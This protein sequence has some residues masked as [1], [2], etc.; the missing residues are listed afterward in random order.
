MR[1]RLEV[2]RPLPEDRG[3]PARPPLDVAA[4][5]AG[6]KL[7]VIGGTGFLG[8]VWWAMLLHRYP[9]IGHLYLVVRA[10][11]T[12]DPEARFWADVATS[13]CLAPLRDAHPGALYDAF[14]KS[15]VTPID[16]DVSR[17]FCGVSPD[18]IA[19]LRGSVDAVVN[20]AGLVDF[21]PPL[22]E[23]LD[24]NA[25][26]MQNLVALA[27]E[28]GSSPQ[29]EDGASSQRALAE[30][31]ASRAAVPVLHTS[32]CYVA[33]SRCGAVDEVDPRH[34][35]FPR[36]GELERAHWDPAREIAECVDLV[37]QAR[38]RCD[39]AFRQSG[40]VDQAKQNLLAR[41]EPVTGEPF[42][43]ELKRVRRKFIES[44]LADTGL[45]R[46]KFWGWPNTYTYTKSIGEQI[47]AASGV[48]F[49]IVR[50]AVI[51]SS[52]EFPFP[53]WNEGINTSAPMLYMAL[54]GQ[55]QLPAG[56]VSLDVIPV[57]M[58]AAGM[59][60][61]L[62]EL[63]EGTAPP[64]YQMGTADTNAC[65]MA[66]FIELMGLYKRKHWQRKNTSMIVKLVQSRLEPRPRDKAEW[67]RTGPLAIS[68]A[69]STVA[70]FLRKAPGPARSTA[71]PLARSL[72][73]F[74]RNEA[75]IG[76]ILGLFTPFTTDF[77][78]KFSCKNTRAAMG[79]LVPAD[80]EKLLWA[81][82]ALDWRA[83]MTEIHVPALERLIFPQ[84]D[85]GLRKPT[86]PLRRHETLVSLQDEMAA[87]H[88]LTTAL[89]LL[90]DQG[91][92]HLSFAEWREQS[93]AV[94]ARLAKAGVGRDDRV[95]LAGR[96]HPTWAIAYF[97]ILRT[98]ATAV[99][100]DAG[101]ETSPFENVLGAS[102]AKAAVVDGPF[103]DKHRAA[104]GDGVAVLD[105]RAACEQ[106]F[107]SP[108]SLS[109]EGRGSR[110]STNEG[111]LAPPVVEIRG[112][113]PAS[114]IFTSGTT[115][116]PKGVVLT[117]DNLTSLIAALAPV[118]PLSRG[119]RVLSVLPLHHTFEFTCGMLLPLSRGARI[120]YLD[121]ISGERVLTGLREARITGMIGVP[122]LWSLLERRIMSRVEER[123]PIAKTAFNLALELNR[124]AGQKLGLNLGRAL[125]GVVHGELGGHL[126]TLVSGGAA[127][128][129]ETFDLFQG[130]G[131]PLAEGYGLTEA[132]PVLSVAPPDVR[133]RA[134]HVGK[135]IPGVEIRIDEPDAAGVGEVIARGPNVMKEYVD[136]PDATAR[137]LD[138][139][140]F[141]HTGDLGKLDRR[142]NLVIVGRKKEV[143][144]AASGEN[145]Y[146]DDVEAMVGVV[147]DVE[148]IAI[149]GLPD[150][151]GGERVG[152]LAVAGGDPD[153]PRAERHEAARRSL[154]RALAKLPQAMRPSVVFVHD[155][156]LPR[157]ATR[158]VKRNEVRETLE[159]LLAATAPGPGGERGRTSVRRA[160]LAVATR[161]VEVTDATTLRGDLGLDSLLML[162]LVM[163]L[164]T[165]LGRSLDAE[166]I[167]EC[168][169]IGD[170]E[171]L[172][173]LVPTGETLTA[174]DSPR[175]DPETDEI[176]VPE[177]MQD[178]VKSLISRA[179]MG[180]YDRVMRPRVTGRAFIPHNR[181]CIVAANHASHLDMGFVKYALGTYGEGLVT[182]AA[183][184]YFFEGNRWKRAYFKNFTNLAPMSRSGSVR[185]SLRQAGDI[186]AAGKTVL[187]FPEGT[188]SRDGTL[189]PFK[190]AIGRLALTHHKD[191]LPVYLGGT[192]QAFPPGARVPRKRE[193]FA[194]IGLP[195][196]IDH[197]RRLTDGMKPV[198]A[199]R[200]VAR[201]AQRAV[202]MLRDGDVLDLSRIERQ[203]LEQ[204]VEH[205]LVTLFGELPARF[206][207]G[208]TEQ[209]VS[210]Y[211]TLGNDDA[212]KWT[213]RVDAQR[214][215]VVAGKPEGGKADCVLKTTPE[216]FTRIVREAYTPS[217]MEFMSG[218]IKSNDVA[219]L[220]K[221]QEV[222]GL[223]G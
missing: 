61:A 84:I 100:V 10:K 215:E 52:C 174:T 26:G 7:L 63:V 73:G 154:T 218:A 147:P 27:R 155:A 208:K 17:P 207:P 79:R 31:H 25:F 28:L 94:A 175:V 103:Y 65:S 74:A 216:M 169:T 134:G 151:R 184:D 97:G 87:R 75:R 33:G 131:L 104:F 143:I 115:G 83:W 24:A 15:K 149:V 188:R 11:G 9:E 4:T 93:M 157:T 144:V 129:R 201:L 198:D 59:V 64:V 57:D 69:V 136:D 72:E 176:D 68:R 58:V 82:E 116:K 109:L 177:S 123:G 202:E 54:Q 23:A 206:Q 13:E 179:Q 20:A 163:A 217:P 171:R 164:E 135:P 120:V 204:K 223:S 119:D 156:A 105:L 21:N 102:R 80:R 56:D 19:K 167:A 150:P 77:D 66:R 48:P 50:P 186:I 106:L 153:Q 213:V 222:F 30:D 98:G 12:Q 178:G 141:L 110:T 112:D 47:L 34:A 114:L 132:S 5:L 214:C 161:K 108:P 182:L 40:F 146:P 180:F 212:S 219:L 158:K 89:Q 168:E 37:A 76:E 29:R 166:R 32:T 111:E 142:G 127:L 107:E 113:H 101:I 185:Q 44:Q 81:P 53:G 6:K 125:F 139:A 159:R 2:P 200:E 193:I 126:R 209:P 220:M 190:P 39:D 210:F 138:A 85:D 172:V 137:A 187:L 211:F 196:E 181:S 96:N 95:V 122:A 16:G 189:S 183:Q 197:L 99:P 55:V 152:C 118:F 78:Y 49:T 45:E 162:E 8:K 140:G 18:L 173:A 88:E 43:D 205:P 1:W 42:E 46:A 3:V 170:L 90:T 128:P 160:A 92:A 62:A 38:Q 117:H 51:E 194:R 121:E 41:G 14:L 70:S 124:M 199:A 203:A 67:N 86:K 165:Q 71:A 191:I 221:F 91:L 195:L 148:E 35:P 192:H 133:A 145:V 36:A 130:L 22:D 60:A